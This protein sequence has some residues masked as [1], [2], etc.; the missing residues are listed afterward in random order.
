[1][2]FEKYPDL[3]VIFVGN[4]SDLESTISLE[5]VKKKVFKEINNLLEPEPV[6]TSK[7]DI[8]S[9]EK[10]RK[11]SF[12]NILGESN[13]LFKEEEKHEEAYFDYAPSMAMPFDISE[14]IF[15]TDEKFGDYLTTIIDSKNYKDN[16][17][18]NDLYL[19]NEHIVILRKVVL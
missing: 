13:S 17:S 18:P 2:N 14:D 4:K 9:I 19:N 12:Q 7:Y 15:K 8:P 16:N 1:M 5:D 11:F 3:K 10:K 6:H